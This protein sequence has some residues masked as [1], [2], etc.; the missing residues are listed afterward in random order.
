MF[1][2]DENDDKFA[3]GYITEIYEGHFVIPDLGP[4][5]A[6]GLANPRDFESVT[7]S[8]E[9]D[10]NIKDYNYKIIHKFGG[11]LY[12][13]ERNDASIYDIVSWHGNYVPY[14]YDLKKFCPVFSVG[15]DHLDP[16][17]FTVLTAQTLEPGVAVCDFVIFPPRWN[18]MQNSF[19]PPYYH[20]NCMSEFVGNIIGDIKDTTFIGGMSQTHPVFTP[21]GVPS[22]VYNKMSKEISTEENNKPLPPKNNDL[23]F[24][25]E[26]TYLWKFT[27]WSQ[28]IDKNGKS[29]K[30]LLQ[31]DYL[32]G[33][34]DSFNID[35][36]LKS[37]L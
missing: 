13:S 20:R 1:N 2:P 37:K 4:I 6:N 34:Y 12:E 9:F 11:K 16:S 33:R 15:Y 31:R 28:Q 17:I 36:K 7:A 8:F 19:R 25:F 21:H 18:V 24:M 5:G 10:E 27:K 3:R 32:K 14:R 22:D 30:G 23:E 35:F 26:S 29:T